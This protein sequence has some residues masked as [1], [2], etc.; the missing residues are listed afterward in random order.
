[1]V[2][3]VVMC[4]GLLTTSCPDPAEYQAAAAK[5]GR[6]P[7]A[8]LKLAIWCE[9]HGR[10]AGRLKHL[11]AALALDPQNAAVRGMMG[12]IAYGGRWLSPEK[13]GE[14]VQADEALMAQLAQYEAKRQA[15]PETADGHWKLALWCEQNGLKAE[16]MAH[17]TTV[18][19]LDLQRSD[20]WR[21]LGCQLYHGRWLNVEHL[22]AER[23]EDEAQ[24][25]ADHHWQ[26]ILEKWKKELVAYSPQRERAESTLKEISDP[27]AVPSIRRVF[28]HG[29]PAQQEL[30]VAM[31][32]RIDFPASSHVLAGLALD[33][34]APRVQG[35][36]IDVLKQR[37]PRD[38]IEDLIGLLRRPLRY[39]VR[40]VGPSGE[41][42]S[43]IVQGARSRTKR[44]YKVP[45][46]VAPLPPGPGPSATQPVW[47]TRQIGS[48]SLSQFLRESPVEQLRDLI[49]LERPAAELAAHLPSG[50]HTK[51]WWKAYHA[52]QSALDW[53]VRRV[54]S[55]NAKIESSNLTVASVLTQITGKSLGGDPDDWLTWWNDRIGYHYHRYEPPVTRTTTI[56][57]PIRIQSC[58]AAGTPVWTLTGPRPIESLRVGDLVLSQDTATGALG[59]EPIVTVHHNPPDA[60]L[61]IRLKGDTLDATCYHRFWRPGR[62]WAR[63]RD[64]QPGDPLRTLGGRTEV[65]AV[66]PGSVQ[67]VFNLDVARSASF[68]VGSQKELVHDNS[69]PPPVLTP[70]D[71]EPSLVSIGHEGE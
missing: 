51:R 58:F 7:Q 29:N 18:T 40:P 30:A 19:R 36:A 42:G 67:P 17:F 39:A 12:L 10:D 61:H 60:V 68:F 57:V 47:R 24:T 4:A 26:P 69:L 53:D 20:A 23:A 8:H 50:P 21:R 28:G 59:Y 13:V 25:K 65:V 46:V 11:A 56:V 52:T 54:D 49:S 62:G 9:A 64:L 35:L 43:L 45:G 38:F 31:L 41:P 37:D 6:D 1:M 15:T 3:V 44:I 71:A 2:P 55:F 32:S 66:E 33:P 34:R 27:R 5:A 16:A 70:F 14:T 48:L 22:A 63:A